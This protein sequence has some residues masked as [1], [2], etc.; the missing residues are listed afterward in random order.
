DLTS[1]LEYRF[2]EKSVSVFDLNIIFPSFIHKKKV[3]NDQKDVFYHLIKNI[4][5]ESFNY[6]ILIRQINILKV[7]KDVRYYS[8]SYLH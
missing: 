1:E 8:P 6:T 7:L 3:F 2:D 4:L 5:K